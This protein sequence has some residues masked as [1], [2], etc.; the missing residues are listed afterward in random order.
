MDKNVRQIFARRVRETR[1]AAGFSGRGGKITFCETAQISR[2]TLD[3]IESGTVNVS[4]DM[5][6]KIAS[7]LGVDA[8]E[9]LMPYD[10]RK[11]TV[12]AHRVYRL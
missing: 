10:E 6:E 1:H 11:L 9:L 8:Y 12:N 4:I 7:A 3:A 2:P 5:V